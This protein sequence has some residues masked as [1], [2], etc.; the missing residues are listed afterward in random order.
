MDGSL[1]RYCLKW[2]NL[3]VSELEVQYRHVKLISIPESE[4]LTDHRQGPESPLWQ[5][6]EIPEPPSL[7]PRVLS[8]MFRTLRTGYLAGSGLSRS[9]WFGPGWTAPVSGTS[10]GSLCLSVQ[11]HPLCQY[12]REHIENRFISRLKTHV[13]TQKNTIHLSHIFCMLTLMRAHVWL[14]YK[15][16]YLWPWLAV[17]IQTKSYN[18]WSS[19]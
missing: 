3:T 19:Y 18:C 7:A 8:G 15:F 1:L 6:P 4:I 11:S 13:I 5:P 17:T 14:Y 2:I 10:R 9:H 16:W 12:L